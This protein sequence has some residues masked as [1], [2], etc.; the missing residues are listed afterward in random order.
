M[1]TEHFTWN[2][3]IPKKL[4]QANKIQFMVYKKQKYWD[5]VNCLR[6]KKSSFTN[7]LAYKISYKSKWFK[8]F[9]YID[10]KFLTELINC[11]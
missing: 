10:A 9:I 2:I 11:F 8:V 3:K 7:K 5:K 6:N 4:Y 1:F